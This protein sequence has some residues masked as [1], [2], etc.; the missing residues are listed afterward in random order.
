M[1]EVFDLCLLGQ[2]C[3]IHKHKPFATTSDNQIHYWQPLLAVPF[4]KAVFFVV[5]C[6]VWTDGSFMG[7]ILRR[8]RNE[9]CMRIVFFRLSFNSPTLWCSMKQ[10]Q[11]SARSARSVV[12]AGVNVQYFACGHSA[13][14]CVGGLHFLSIVLSFPCACVCLIARVC[15]PSVRVSF[16]K[17]RA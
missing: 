14:A 5:E 4:A 13:W 10:Q 12:R 9:F 15:G 6:V 8:S 2:L 17:A 7:C 1:M 11:R 16:E 3:F